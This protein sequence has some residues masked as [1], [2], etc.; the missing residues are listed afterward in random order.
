M[1]YWRDT[2]ARWTRVAYSNA[3]VPKSRSPADHSS[4]RQRRLCPHRL[5]ASQPVP[6]WSP[7]AGRLGGEPAV[8]EPTLPSSQGA[9]DH[10]RTGGSA[11]HTFEQGTEI[12]TCG[13]GPCLRRVEPSS[14]SKPAGIP[15][16]FSQPYRSPKPS[17]C[18]WPR[19]H[20]A[21][22]TRQ[23]RHFVHCPHPAVPMPIRTLW[24]RWLDLRHRRHKRPKMS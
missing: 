11:F 3:V 16:R 8:E 12:R 9:R 23:A 7:K 24:K 17:R 4:P 14:S 21:D 6:P 1:R 20:H 22:G 5:R 13:R 19:I 10:S 2:F 18:S 15:V